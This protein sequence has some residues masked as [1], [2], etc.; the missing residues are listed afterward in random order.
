[1]MSKIKLKEWVSYLG[2]GLCTS[3]GSKEVKLLKNM[4][5]CF[6]AGPLYELSKYG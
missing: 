6:T 3:G 1:M 5:P 2:S 4:R